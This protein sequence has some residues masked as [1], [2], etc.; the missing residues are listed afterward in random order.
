MI[1]GWAP[2]IWLEAL[3]K[4]IGLVNYECH[5]RVTGLTPITGKPP[6]SYHQIFFAGFFDLTENILISAYSEEASILLFSWVKKTRSG[7][8]G[9]SIFS[10]CPFSCN[11]LIFN[12]EYKLSAPPGV[13]QF[14][15]R[16]TISPPQRPLSSLLPVQ[17]GALGATSFLRMLSWSLPGSSCTF[18]HLPAVPGA[19]SP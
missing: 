1:L 6:V 19:A 8:K 4:T 15:Q 2:K 5:S 14:C 18:S 13:F 11:F 16:S 12:R 7:S 10:M 3:Q 17:E 9:V